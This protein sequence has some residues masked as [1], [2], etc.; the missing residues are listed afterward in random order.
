MQFNFLNYRIFVAGIKVNYNNLA[1]T[2]KKRQ[3]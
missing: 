1:D 2:N 3:G